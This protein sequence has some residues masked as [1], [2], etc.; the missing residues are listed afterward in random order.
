MVQPFLTSDFSRLIAAALK[1]RSSLLL[2]PMVGTTNKSIAAMVPPGRPMPP[3]R[4]TQ[5][6]IEAALL[7]V[8]IDGN[9]NGRTQASEVCEG[10]R[11]VAVER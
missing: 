9:G 2:S 4:E 6:A 5:E 10:H 3:F 8:S 7:A 1:Q 11:Q